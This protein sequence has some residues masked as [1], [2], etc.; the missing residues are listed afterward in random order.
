MICLWC[1]EPVAESEQHSDFKQPMHGEC[2]FRT[3]MGSVAHIEHRCMCYVPGAGEHD[4]PHMTK[5]QAARAAVLAW[6]FWM[7]RQ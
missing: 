4:P 2:G 6:T 7:Q 5:R 3:I 1:G